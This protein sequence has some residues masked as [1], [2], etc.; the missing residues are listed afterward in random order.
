MKA[1]IHFLTH[2]LRPQPRP[3]RPS[4]RRLAAFS[5]RAWRGRV[6][7]EQPAEHRSQRIE[8]LLR[9]LDAAIA[10]LEADDA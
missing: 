2:S 5:L 9:R 8:T 6:A 3:V 1:I 7:I 4:T 10:E